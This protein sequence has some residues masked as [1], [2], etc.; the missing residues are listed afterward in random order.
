MYES[1]VGVGV[2]LRE[3]QRK[4]IPVGKRWDY[5]ADQCE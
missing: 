1:C 4:H 3:R 2:C 5:Y